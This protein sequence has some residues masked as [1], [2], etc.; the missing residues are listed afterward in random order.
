MKP[1]L[2]ISQTQ[3]ASRHDNRAW[4]NHPS[5]PLTNYNYR[6]TAKNQV[7]SSAARPATKVP[8]FHKLSSEFFRGEATWD[9]IAELFFFI[10]I[11][12]IAAWPV[13][14]MFIAVIRLIRNY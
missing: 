2:Q 3:R 6:P 9:Y 12:G 14:S 7:S 10:L 11:T 5:F 13:M 4:R 8:A 1:T